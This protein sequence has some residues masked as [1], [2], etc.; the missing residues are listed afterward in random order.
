MNKIFCVGF[1]SL[2]FLTSN[3]SLSEF[4]DRVTK[5]VPLS[6]QDHKKSID[7][8]YTNIKIEEDRLI[9]KQSFNLSIDSYVQIIGNNQAFPIKITD[10]KNNIKVIKRNNIP[11]VFLKKGEHYIKGVIILEP[12]TTEILVPDYVS[13]IEVSKENN[14]VD[15]VRLSSNYLHIKAVNTFE[16]IDDE[17]LLDELVDIA[18]NIDLNLKKVMFHFV[19]DKF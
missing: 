13:V 16:N 2:F 12:T 8:I 19:L 5:D 10:N 18:N 1:L 15:M 6:K 9:F 7:L 4:D 17:E 14:Q 3:A 11:Y